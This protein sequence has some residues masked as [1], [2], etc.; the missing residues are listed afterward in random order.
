MQIG[1]KNSIYISSGICLLVIVLFECTYNPFGSEEITRKS[2][3]IFGNIE[4]NHHNSPENV[5]VWLEGFDIGTLTDKSGNFRLE[6]PPREIQPGRGYTG[7]L[8]LYYYVSNFKLDSSVV[9][10]QNGELEFSFG[11]LDEKGHLRRQKHLTKTLDIF[12]DVT[13]STVSEDFDGNI[14]VELFLRAIDNKD[15]VIVEFPDKAKGP[16]SVLFFKKLDAVQ[17]TLIILDNASMIENI[18]LTA[19]SIT[20][21][22]EVWS[23]GFQFIPNFLPRGEYEIIPFFVIRGQTIPKELLLNFGENIEKPGDDFINIPTTRSGGV[24]K[25]TLPN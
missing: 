19:D 13:P 5:F 21:M 1:I 7:S 24:F 4:M 12:T 15:T 6:I 16:L 3:T 22:G 10:I 23:S 20:T 11:D 17:D 9:V 2:N 18:F 14:S 8:K 25:V